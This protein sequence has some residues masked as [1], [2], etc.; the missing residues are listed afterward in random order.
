MHLYQ[1]MLY[2]AAVV[3]I[4]YGVM[5]AIEWGIRKKGLLFRSVIST[6]FICIVLTLMGVWTQFHIFIY[7]SYA[8]CIAIL[9]SRYWSRQIDEASFDK[10][11]GAHYV[12]E[13]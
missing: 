3:A 5:L 8:A 4:M 2:F 13:S 7:Y 6:G 12:Q 9:W 1:F 11:E 10:R